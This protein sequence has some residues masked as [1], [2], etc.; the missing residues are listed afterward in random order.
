ME[1][2]HSTGYNEISLLGLSTG[3]YPQIEKLLRRL[4]ETFRP[5]GVS[6]SLPSLRVNQQLRLLG[7]LL[8][9]DRRD[10]LTLAPEAARDDMRQQIGK[11]I[12]NDDL[13][14]GCRRA[15][16]NGFSR[17]KLYFMCGLPGERPVDLDG[18]FDLSETISRLGKE[19]TGR[20]ATVVANVSNFVPKPQTPF[21]WNA[22]QRREYFQQATA[23]GSDKN[24]RASPCAATTPNPASWKACSVAATGGW[25]MRSNWPGGAAP[26][27]TPGANNFAPK[28]GGKRWPTRAST[29]RASCIDPIRP[30][31]HC[32]GT[33]WAF[34]RAAATWNKSSS[35]QRHTWQR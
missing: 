10:G 15:M 1:A 11:D 23:C 2:Y 3:D 30:A 13:V 28:S 31:P 19:V 26:A 25:A 14:E 32:P 33:I 17:A 7:E 9:T 4:Q 8:N 35:G 16:E 27:S 21:Q 29:S 22:M 5:L 20:F 12:T 6:I 34:A 24:S 18:I